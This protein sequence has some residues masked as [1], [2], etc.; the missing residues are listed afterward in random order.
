[1]L[2]QTPQEELSAQLEEQDSLDDCL[3][4]LLFLFWH[5]MKPIQNIRRVLCDARGPCT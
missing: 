4:P 3:L 2:E 1:M 5:Q